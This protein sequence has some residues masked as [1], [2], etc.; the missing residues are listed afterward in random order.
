MNFLK[1]L[2]TYSPFALT[3]LLVPALAAAQS[4]SILSIQDILWTFVNNVFG[5]L[6]GY[7]AV[8]LDTSIEMFIVG[9]GD[10]FLNLGVGNAVDQ[11][12][13]IV[14]DIFNL[15]FIFGLVWIG[16]KMILNSDDSNTRRWLVNL[17]MA[18]LLVNFSL[19]ITKFIVDFSNILATEIFINGFVTSISGGR[20]ISEIFAQMFGLTTVWDNSWINK[21]PAVTANGNGGYMYI[22]GAAIIFLIGAFCFAAGAFMIMIRFVALCLYMVFSP[23]MFLGWVFPQMQSITSKYWSGFLGRAFFAPAYILLVYLSVYVMR[24]FN[25]SGLSIGQGLNVNTLSPAQ[26]NS[27]GEIFVNFFLVAMFMIASV[28]VG[29]KMSADGAGVVMRV[30]KN[31]QGR[32]Q[33]G[34]QN[35]AMGSG[36]FVA[37]NTAGYGAQGVN[38]ATE[39]MQKR[40][41]RLDA[42]RQAQGLRRPND[43]TDKLIRGALERGTKVSVAGSMT[44]KEVR[45]RRTDRNKLNLAATEEAN[46]EETLRNNTLPPITST[47]TAAEISARQEARRVQQAEV[48]DMTPEE[49]LERVRTNKAEVLSA[50]F[51]SLLSDAQVT[52][53]RASGLLTSEE[54]DGAGGLVENRDAGTFADINA[55]LE[56]SN[57]STENLTTATEQLN[58]IVSTMSKERLQRMNPALLQN[59]TIASRLSDTQLDE[60]RD[61]GRVSSTNMQR[62][63]DERN[64][65]FVN[66]A[67]YG[68][69]GNPASAGGSDPAFQDRQR[70]G[71]F[72]NPQNAGKLPVDVLAATASAPYLTPRI[73]EEFLLNNPSD[74][75]IAQVRSNIRSY[76]G[77]AAAAPNAADTWQNWNKRTVPGRQFGSVV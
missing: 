70:R 23:L 53:L 63:R 16:V 18:A 62:I 66:I 46:R 68:S 25:S 15:T 10:T 73:I 11:A 27:V 32:A 5:S 48:Q 8:L 75:H 47:S 37:R 42:R 22:F 74:S 49:L 64:D 51:A 50:E 30:G 71:L 19:F 1:K 58:R 34:V 13:I 40:Y 12:W 2:A 17:I 35:A 7:A 20:S 45:D 29:S 24:T 21:A 76:L 55:T 43:Y 31:L 56:N 59:S 54:L 9:F 72:K 14:R 3:L 26:F 69:L 61:S 60:M 67:R 28:M 39:A 44:R 33:R 4:G 52:A 77:S 38:A 65:G 57:A 6:V 41:N 36:R